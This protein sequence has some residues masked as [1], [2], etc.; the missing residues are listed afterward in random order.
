M[1]FQ[2][3]DFDRA[4]ALARQ[5]GTKRQEGESVFNKAGQAEL[6]LVFCYVEN[7]DVIGEFIENKEV[8]SRLSDIEDD[9]VPDSARFPTQTI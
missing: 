5:L 8:W 7:L 6:R 3:E 2:A 4:L 9:L 1:V